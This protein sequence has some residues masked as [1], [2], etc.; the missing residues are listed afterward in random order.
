MSEVS[1]KDFAKVVNTP[2]QLL[3]EQLAAAGVENKTAESVISDDEKSALLGFL[4]RSHKAGATDASGKPARVT[5]E[6]R[7]TSELK[8]RAPA[9]R[10][11]VGRAKPSAR[12]VNVVVRKKRTYVKRSLLNEGEPPAEETVEAEVDSGAEGLAPE[13]TA[14]E[15]EPEVV[16]TPAA[17]ADALP[18]EQK[19]VEAVTTPAVETPPVSEIPLPP[20]ESDDAARAKKGAKPVKDKDRRQK[21]EVKERQV[22][23][24]R[25]KL[26]PAPTR[27]RPIHEFAQPTEKIVHEVEIGDTISVSD[28]ARK[29]TVKAGE[30]IKVLMG[31][32]T[33]AT[34]NEMLDQDTAVLVVE[35]MGHTPKTVAENPEE[36]LLGT[37]LDESKL[38]PRAPV[39]TV[40]G[41]VDHGKTSLLDYI[42]S[43]RVASGEAGG[44]TQHIGAYHVSTESGGDITFLDTPGHAAFSEMRARGARLTDLVVLVVAADD[45][46]MPQTIEAVKHA[47]AAGVPLVVAV[48]KI[49]KN[50]ADPDRVRN[51]LVVQEVVPEEWGGE[52]QFVNVSAHTGEGVDS[53]IESLVLQSE[54][55][56]LKAMPDGPAEGIV[57]E[58]KLDKGRGPV[59]TVLV[60]HGALQKGDVVL[61]GTEYGRVRMLLDENG[62]PVE[63]VG[64]S[65]PAEVLGLSG[66]PD[67]GESLY[68][69]VDERR[70]REIAE[71]R[72]T[73]ERTHT[74]RQQQLQQ[75]EE[76]FEQMG[77]ET[78]RQRLNLILK[79]DVKGS[80]EALAAA[81]LD[82]TTDEVEVKL[83]SRGVGG[84]NETDVNLAASSGAMLIGFNVRAD[85]SAR[86]RA[87]EQNIELIYH[88]I[89][90]EVIDQIK[91]RIEGLH[92]PEVTQRIIG[93]AEVREVFHSKKL[94]DIA[95]CRVV[96][97]SIRRNNPIRVLRENVVIYEGELESL[98]RFKD[99]VNEVKNGMD[100]GIGVKNYDDVQ[101]GD[102]IEVFER[103]VPSGKK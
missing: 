95:G 69:V 60:Q 8:Q 21:S 58:A 7:E 38:R 78:E 57:V 16:E 5:L 85:A 99:D 71:Y 59:A 2:V 62:K 100:C 89:I 18:E 19:E 4:R 53:L 73:R 23:A 92:E 22:R 52:T 27:S 79:T 30:V 84:I 46:V 82:L 31:M 96:E 101:P 40:M 47:R 32:G 42:R 29:M 34:I 66:V 63:S 70:A 61:A 64:P 35:E 17:E 77:A 68:V 37:E 48:N 14:A 87:Q 67:V 45:G 28:L 10:G 26:R 81:L 98:R 103:L 39:V 80:A 54:M 97:G 83:I 94:G 88:S 44:I 20:P 43:T 33:M 72:G 91:A 12:K 90:Y 50:G 15:V 51:E 76:M 11:P 1:V 36:A 74:L 24:A 93:L 3:I 55:L 65:M 25:R 13:V 86:R 102:Q 56:E 6:R 75:R 49:D 9:S 41:H